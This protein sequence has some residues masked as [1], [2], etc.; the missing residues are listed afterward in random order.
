MTFHN[1]CLVVFHPNQSD[2]VP[3][4]IMQ[5]RYVGKK[6]EP[7]INLDVN[8]KCFSMRYFSV[9]FNATQIFF[10][11]SFVVYG[12][13]LNDFFLSVL[14]SIQTIVLKHLRGNYS[15]VIDRVYF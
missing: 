4:G 15:F 7:V 12:D 11:D 9:E 10:T 6:I 13:K 5:I 1:V 8:R 14:Y 2:I 3:L